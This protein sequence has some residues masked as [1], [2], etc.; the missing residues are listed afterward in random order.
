MSKT[1]K[2]TMGFS[3]DPKMKTRIQ[4]TARAARL[5]ISWVIN[6]CI[7]VGIA[8]VERKIAK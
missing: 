3:I 4:Q 7:S 2:I 6:E 8:Q 1:N 5:P